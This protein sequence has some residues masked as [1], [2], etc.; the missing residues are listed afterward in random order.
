MR[1]PKCNSIHIGVVKTTPILHSKVRIRICYNCKHVFETV[2]KVIPPEENP[3]Q[4]LFKK[5]NH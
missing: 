1:C 2:E 4:N 3:S 5:D